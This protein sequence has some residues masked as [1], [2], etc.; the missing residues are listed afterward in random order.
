MHADWLDPYNNSEFWLRFELGGDFSNL[1]QPIARLLQAMDRSRTISNFLFGEASDC[2]AIVAVSRAQGWKKYDWTRQYKEIGIDL[3]QAETE[4]IAAYNAFDEN[5]LP[6]RWGAYSAA[7]RSVRDVFLWANVTDEMPVS[8]SGGA[9]T[10]LY[11]KRLGIVLELYDDRG[12][13]VG[14]LEPNG[15]VELYR[16]HA[17]WLVENTRDD[18]EEIFA[19]LC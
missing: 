16:Q 12:L 15:L 6:M 8:P 4:W 7:S 3:S 13:L 18:A 10:Y 2:L 19:P 14:A 5:H 11:S 17:D 1:E 9:L